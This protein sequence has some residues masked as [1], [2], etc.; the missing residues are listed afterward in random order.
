MY[1]RLLERF[2]VR[3]NA[4][5]I[6]LSSAE[7]ASGISGCDGLVTGW[8]CQPLTPAVFEQGQALKIIA[9]S[10]GTVKGIVPREVVDR[11]VVPRGICVFSANQAIAYNVAESTIGLLIAAPRRWTEH[12]AAFRERGVWRDPGMAMDGRFLS[13]STVGVVGASKVGR[14]VIRMLGVFDVKILVYDPCLS[15]WEAGR[16]G[17]E[18]VGLDELFARS[19]HV[20]VHAPSIPQTNKMIGAQQLSLLRDGGTIVNT[21]RG[22]VIDEDALVAELKTGRIAAALDVTD[23]EPPRPDSALRG[24]RGVMV[25]PHLSGCGQYGYFRIGASTL[26]ALEDFFAGKPVEGAVEFGAYETLA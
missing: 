19:D 14:E 1:A 7:I 20:S 12:V 13:G 22:S 2:D 21:S 25:T 16:L 8:G 6:N 11:Y 17:A 23:P 10:A 15:E 24:L 4:Q 26:E 9:H 3:A 18:K 5:E